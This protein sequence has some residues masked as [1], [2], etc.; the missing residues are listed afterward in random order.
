M[1]KRYKVLLVFTLGLLL[2]APLTIIGIRIFIIAP[3][4]VDGV[5]MEPTYVTGDYILANKLSG[6]ERGDV[7]VFE[8]V[9]KI[10]VLRIVGLP[11]E[12]VYVHDDGNVYINGEILDEPYLEDRPVYETLIPPDIILGDDRYYLLGD[13]RD[14][15]YDSRAFGS[16]HKKYLI[17]KIILKLDWLKN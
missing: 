8:N 11:G 14:T 4:Y 13:N 15:S 3:Y 2:S 1:K 10:L 6:Y 9:N 7:V 12:E 5:S 17:G 16:I